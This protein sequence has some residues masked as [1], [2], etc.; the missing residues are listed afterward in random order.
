MSW[1]LNLSVRFKYLFLM[2]LVILASLFI[3]DHVNNKFNMND[4]RVM[5]Y[6]ADAFLNG[7]Q[8]YDVPFGL[9]TGYYK[10]SPFTLLYFLLF[11]VIPFYHASVMH[12]IS[13]G[14]ATFFSFL[15]IEKILLQTFFR[16]KKPAFRYLSAVLLT[17]LVHL[18][19]EIHLGNINI[20]IVLLLVLSVQ[21]AINYKDWLAGVLL[22]IVIFAKPYFIICLLPFLLLRRFQVIYATIISGISFLIVSLLVF[23][24]DRGIDLYLNWFDA[25]LAH[26]SYLR[27]SHTLI[28][29]FNMIFD[30]S[31]SHRYSF[32]LLVI[33][34]A[35]IYLFIEWKRKEVIQQRNPSSTNSKLLII[36]FFISMAIIPNILITD[37]EHFLFSLPL[38]FFVLIHCH[39]HL[40]VLPRIGLILVCVLYGGNFSDIIGI[41]MSRIINGIGLLGISNLLFI[42]IALKFSLKYFKSEN[43]TLPA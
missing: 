22:A 37:T 25:M 33:L 29:L 18:H 24:I 1:W 34:S 13:I 14:V 40:Q 31:F 42:S 4:F 39:S 15:I 43:T 23:G 27:S 28:S 38:I 20:L 35:I 6:A 3:G 7:D 16:N 10:Y 36:Y 32:H 19:R 17:I 5:Y 8:V 2:L 9:D 11:T 41:E 26:N 21:S 12:Y 30:T